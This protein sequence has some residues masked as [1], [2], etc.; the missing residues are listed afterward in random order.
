MQ[1]LEKQSAPNTLKEIER[2]EQELEKL[3]NEYNKLPYKKGCVEFK[4]VLNKIG[5]PYYYYY[6]RVKE[7]HT[8]R[9]IYLGDISEAQPVIQSLKRA[10]ELRNKI[11]I[12]KS[13][14]KKLKM[15]LTPSKSPRKG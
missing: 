5:K 10:K 1:V 12:L 6:Y 11:K 4:Y 9:S 13:E 3:Q 15:S 8:R 14:I 2:L 7:G